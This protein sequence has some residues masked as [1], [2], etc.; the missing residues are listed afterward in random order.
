MLS[1]SVCVYIRSVTALSV[2]P[3]FSDTLAMVCAVC[4]G[5]AGKAVPELVG[6]ADPGH[7]ISLQSFAGNGQDFGDVLAQG[8]LPV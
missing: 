1:W 4:D 7:R 3:S 6:G 8:Y 5:D 2:C